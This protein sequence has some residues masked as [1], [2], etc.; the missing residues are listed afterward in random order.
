[1]FAR[2]IKVFR[3]F[4]GP[5]LQGPARRGRRLPGGGA[6]PDGR[7]GRPRDRLARSA[8]CSRPAW[9][10]RSTPLASPP[11]AWRSTT[12]PRRSRSSSS[13]QTSARAMT[14]CTVEPVDFELDDTMH[15]VTLSTRATT[16]TL[17]MRV[18]GHDT[19]TVSARSVIQRETTGME[20]ALVLDNTGSMWG[21]DY[22]AMYN[23]AID[24][25]RYPLRRRNRDRQPL[26]QRR[27][28]RRQRSTSATARTSWLDI[29]RSRGHRCQRL[30][31]RI[32]LEGLRHGAGLSAGHQR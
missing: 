32:A 28:L 23:A 4:F 2:S 24:L 15:F 16:P 31:R 26:G 14:R 10:R 13:T 1:M 20:L 22:T 17:F 18:F 6:D 11:A 8:T 19:M 27:A 29:H 25:D 5:V 21:A 30:S 7:G 12:T 3:S 9:A